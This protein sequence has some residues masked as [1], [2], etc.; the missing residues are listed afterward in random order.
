MTMFGAFDWGYSYGKMKGGSRPAKIPAVISTGFMLGYNENLNPSAKNI[1][2]RTE[3]GHYFIGKLAQ[4]EGRIFHNSIRQDRYDDPAFDAF[5][6]GTLGHVFKEDGKV[7]LVTGLPPKFYASHKPLLE[8][9]LKRTHTFQLRGVTREITV[10]RLTILPQLVGTALDLLYTDEGKKADTDL[11]RLKMGILDPGF[12][13]TDLAIFDKGQY[14]NKSVD[15]FRYTMAEVAKQVG[16][17]LYNEYQLEIDD[18]LRVDEIVRSGHVSIE[19]NTYDVSH[20][21]DWAKKS[22]ALA[23]ANKVKSSWVQGWEVD[24]LFIT[25]GGGK[26]LYPWLKEVINCELVDSP[27]FANVN[28]YFKKARRDWE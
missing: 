19:G 3:H 7:S 16:D 15:S 2:V 11:H 5:V 10:S 13:T 27:Q 26:E 4:D 21:T 8:N 22:I 17:L 28:G 18:V 20:I 25:G 24:K 9:A 12:G 1:D 23:V 6:K 14:L